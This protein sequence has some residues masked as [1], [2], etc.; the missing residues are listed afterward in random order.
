[1]KPNRKWI[2]DWRIGENPSREDQIAYELLEVFD[3]FWHFEGLDE[4]SKT[5]INRYSGALHSLGGY[6]IEK[7]VFDEDGLHKTTYNLLAEYVGRDDGP[8]ICADHET[9]QNEIDMVCR[10]LYRFMKK[11]C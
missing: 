3:D 2:K 10:K 7:A 4:K 6:L 9:W 8:L 11:N 1:M 5:T